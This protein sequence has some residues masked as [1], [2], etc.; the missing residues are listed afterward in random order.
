MWQMV[1][2]VLGS[3]CLVSGVM[4][5]F[6]RRRFDKIAAVLD[7]QYSTSNVREFLDTEVSVQKL[8]DMLDAYVD[9]NDKLMS[10]SHGLGVGSLMVGIYLLLVALLAF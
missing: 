2:I 3:L 9:V 7:R 1:S 8:H 4:L 5:L 10:V 6:F